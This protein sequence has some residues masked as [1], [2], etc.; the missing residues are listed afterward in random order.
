MRMR[1]LERQRKVREIE[2]GIKMRSLERLSSLERS[3][4]YENLLR[5]ERDYGISRI[6]DSYLYRYPV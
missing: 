4:Q 3:R 6:A 2:T 1:E 5:I